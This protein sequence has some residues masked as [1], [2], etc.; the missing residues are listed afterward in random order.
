MATNK[1]IVLGITGYPGTGKSTLARMLR[2]VKIPVQEADQVVAQMLQ[3]PGVIK[4]VEDSFPNAVQAHTIDKARLAEIV[5]QDP[6]KL[7]ML[8]AI[9]HPLVYQEHQRF[10]K[11]NQEK[12]LIVLEIPLLFET[13]GEKLCDM[14]LYTTCSQELAQQRVKKRGWSQERYE[15]TVQ[16]LLPE[17][18]KKKKSQII[19]DTN[20]SKVKTWHQL[21]D[22]LQG[23]CNV[24]FLDA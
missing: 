7:Q 9:L 8:E 5:F 3:S 23:I 20:T 14:V 6:Q 24:G 22:A 16:R 21:K 1:T 11:A 13:G 18:V 17:L 10:I 15:M 12:S 4:R 2:L 19:I